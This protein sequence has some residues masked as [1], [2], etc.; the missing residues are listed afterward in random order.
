MSFR[1][2]L[3][4]AQ[5]DLSDDNFVLVDRE[6]DPKYQIMA[7]VDF[8]ESRRKSPIIMFANV[9]GSKFPC[10]VN[11]C[12]SRK[13]IAKSLN[14]SRDALFQKYASALDH[15]IQPVL[16]SKSP[17]QDNIIQGDKVDLYKLPGLYFHEGEGGP[18][19]TAGLVIAKHPLTRI[20][21]LSYN[22]LMI[23][24]KDKMCI[25]MTVGKH[26]WECYSAA[27]DL[28]KPL[29]VCIV[30]GNHPSISLGSLY[31]GAFGIDEYDVIGGLLNKPL[32]IVRATTVDIEIPASSEMVIEGEILQ[33]EVGNEGPFCEFAGYMVEATKKPVVR[34]KAITH[35]Q[36]AVYQTICSGAHYEHLL[37][38]AIPMEANIFQA[39]RAAV[40]S[41][42][43]VHVPTGLTCFVSIKKRAPG[44]ATNVLLAVFSADLYMKQVVIVDEDVD[45]HDT[46]KVLWAMATRMQP[47]RDILVIRNSRGSDLDPSCSEEG[48]TAKFGMDATAKP[49][50]KD[51]PPMGI[52]P[53]E[54]REKVQR[55]FKS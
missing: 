43:D 8:F 50:L 35:R 53:I 30:I 2:F 47:D 28:G 11:A 20:R 4:D 46:R 21:N 5:R 9:K 40:P 3:E 29:E 23:T 41:V 37:M 13:R 39:V 10:V 19:I 12:A 18:Y 52:I 31:P 42:K 17:I 7:A 48:V 15:Q 14:V 16:V 22:R 55:L 54:A 45:V 25:N 6:I 34:V 26:L 24:G 36:G 27:K 38:G 44:Q 51:Y 1:E 49:L 33:D 32:E